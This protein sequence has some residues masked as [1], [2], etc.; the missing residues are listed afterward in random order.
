MN[1]TYCATILSHQLLALLLDGSPAG[2][3][4]ACGIVGEVGVAA[5]AVPV[6]GNGLGVE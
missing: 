1:F 6:A 4:R 5:G 2:A 3:L